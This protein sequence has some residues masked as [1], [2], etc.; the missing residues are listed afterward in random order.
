MIFLTTNAPGLIDEAV[1]SRIHLAIQYG[2]LDQLKR[3]SVWLAHINQLK[4]QQNSDSW[5]KDVPKVEINETTQNH[6]TSESG[7]KNIEALNLSGRDIRNA[8]QTAVKLARFDAQTQAGGGGTVP[9]IIRLKPEHFDNA[10]E[11]KFALKKAI[12]NIHHQTEAEIA[13]ETGQR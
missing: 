2:S 3:R 7:I 11:T 12:E 8:F 10:M 13:A 4:E 6:I 1:V 9:K 5:P